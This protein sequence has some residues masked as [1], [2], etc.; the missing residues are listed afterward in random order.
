MGQLDVCA[1]QRSRR[2]P[3]G[4]PD[5]VGSV[6]ALDLSMKRGISREPFGNAHHF[7]AEQPQLLLDRVVLD[8]SGRRR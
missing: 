8:F 4:L 7:F 2:E 1:R 6:I 5:A 3:S